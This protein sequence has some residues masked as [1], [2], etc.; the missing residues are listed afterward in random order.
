MEDAT[1]YFVEPKNW[2]VKIFNKPLGSKNLLQVQGS[3]LFVI[4]AD[5]VPLSYQG[6]I[7]LHTKTKKLV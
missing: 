7:Q 4:Y 6:Q 2:S 1:I 5:I 3:E